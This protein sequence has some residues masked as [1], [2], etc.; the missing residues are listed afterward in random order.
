MDQIPR[1]QLVGENY[2]RHAHVR[3]IIYKLLDANTFELEIVGSQA[4]PRSIRS[5]G[6]AV[7]NS[8]RNMIAKI[9]R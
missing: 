1:L 6:F 9:T 8:L 2:L 7:N 4:D 3:A 5:T